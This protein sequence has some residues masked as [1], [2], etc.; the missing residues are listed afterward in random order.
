M[1]YAY[2]ISER[3]SAHLSQPTFTPWDGGKKT[4]PGCN[5]IRTV[6]VPLLNKSD[7]P[8]PWDTLIRGRFGQSTKP[9]FIVS[10]TQW[11]A[12]SSL[13]THP[14]SSFSFSSKGRAVAQESWLHASPEPRN[15]D[16][17]MVYK[18]GSK[19]GK[20][21]QTKQDFS[22]VLGKQQEGKRRG[23]SVLGW[24]SNIWLNQDTLEKALFRCKSRSECRHH[25]IRLYSL[26]M[27]WSCKCT[28]KLSAGWVLFRDSNAYV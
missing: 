20:C 11:E 24:C 21:G 14:F 10:W 13:H 4:S 19:A 12:A 7:S 8:R 26:F 9:W 22:Y 5:P 18:S 27:C 15:C 23:G 17:T 2:V 16:L 1:C 6:R 3:S 28:I 25:G